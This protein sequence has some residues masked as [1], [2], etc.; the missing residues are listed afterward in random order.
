MGFLKK[1]IFGP[2][3]SNMY[4]CSKISFS[5]ANISLSTQ[6]IQEN[7]NE[8]TLSPGGFHALDHILLFLPQF[9]QGDIVL[10]LYLKTWKLA[11]LNNIF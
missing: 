6:F 11:E 8:Q 5:S 10:V 1:A 4:L 3:F 9:S 2:L 7:T